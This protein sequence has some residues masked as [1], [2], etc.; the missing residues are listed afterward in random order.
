MV[1]FLSILRNVPDPRT[2]NAT[3]DDLLD[4]QTIAVD[5]SV[6]GSEF[7][8]EFADPAKDRDELLGEFLTPENGLPS[9]D[10]FSRLFWPFDPMALVAGDGTGLT[11]ARATCLDSW[12]C[13]G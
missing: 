4:L 12:I 6:C 5:A 3:H 10:T 1:S 9:H 13:W 2:G 8:V 11:A 7:L